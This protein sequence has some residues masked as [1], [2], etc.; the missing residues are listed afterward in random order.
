MDDR[1]TACPACG[2]FA[3]MSISRVSRSEPHRVARPRLHP[4]RPPLRRAADEV[5]LGVGSRAV[6]LKGLSSGQVAVLERLDGSRSLAQLRDVAAAHGDQPG[7]VDDLLG[8]L[9]RVGAL[10]DPR[11]ER[12][13]HLESAMAVPRHVLVGGPEVLTASVSRALYLA[14][15]G[16]VSSGAA[17]LDQA[18]LS[19]RDPGG[20]LA[21][22]APAPDL[23]VLCAQDGLDPADAAPWTR[24]GISHLAFVTEGDQVV[25]G[26]LVRPRSSPSG[27]CLSCL[28]LHRCDRDAGRVHVLAQTVHRRAPAL[29]LPPG[30]TVGPLT[31]LVGPGGPVRPHALEPALL[32][33]A[34]AIT[35]MVVAAY[36][37]GEPLPAGVTVELS[38]PWPRVDHRLWPPHPRCPAHSVAVSGPGRGEGQWPM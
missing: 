32:A 9:A 1:R 3:D 26:P 35:A 29:A 30:R 38:S 31:A 13:E 15:V 14:G 23:V 6:V 8:L 22:R 12:V 11:A 18:E 5:Q 34:A 19:L 28:E 36:L 20:S 33:A 4:R 17:A 24:H 21:L 37:S 2:R 25:V 27:T 10:A 7:V 16:E